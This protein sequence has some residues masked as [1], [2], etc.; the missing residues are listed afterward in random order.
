MYNAV[1]GSTV[2]WGSHIP[3]FHPSDFR[4]KT[5]DGVADD[6]PLT[7]QEL[8]PH[9]DLNDAMTGVSGSEGRPG[10]PSQDRPT[11]PAP[12]HPPGWKGPC[13]W[14]RQA[15]LALVGF[16]HGDFFSPLRWPAAGHRPVPQVSGR[17]G[18]QLLAQS[19]ELGSPPGGPR[20]G[21]GNHG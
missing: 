13:P 9:Y 7:Y 19:A 14:I 3:R 20:Q 11:L 15:W 18:H 17:F 4:V 5:L 2:H 16:R 1:G 21:P 12:V 8:E 6:W 10:L